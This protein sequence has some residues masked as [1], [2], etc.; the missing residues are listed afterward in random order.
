MAIPIVIPKEGQ[1]M[2][3]ALITKWSIKKG[4]AVKLGDVLCE[5]ESEKASFDIESPVNGVVLAIFFDADTEAPVLTAIAAIG[6]EG[7]DYAHL[8]PRLSSG[9]MD[10]T[11]ENAE[12]NIETVE[13]IQDSK[14]VTSLDES[15]SSEERSFQVSPRA[16]KLAMDKGIP[17]SLI[18]SGKIGKG[19]VTERDIIENQW[20]KS[21]D[22]N[23]CETAEIPLTGVRKVISDKMLTSMQ[24]TAQFTLNCYVE[25]TGFLEYRKKLKNSPEQ[26]GINNITINDMI[27][28]AVAKS[29]NNFK[30]MNCHFCGDRIVK[31]NKV[32]LGCA[33]DTQRGLIVPVI[34]N[35]HE[36]SLERISEEAK[37]LAKEC[38]EG[39]VKSDELSGG[40]FTVSNL[41]NLGIDSFTPILNL[42]QVGI[43]GIGGI[44]LRPVS[45]D[46]KVEFVNHIGLSLTVNHQVIDGA[47]AARFLQT[48]S[49]YIKNFN[50]IMV[51]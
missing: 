1:S 7:E 40:T 37:R 39:K 34:K 50:I 18:T 17:L 23:E 48:V 43:L 38:R 46:G 49:Q 9:N 45:K 51:I 30:E 35:A 24:T 26:L 15:S 12:A 11:D 5:V 28:Y 29:L 41:G 33:V 22:E 36:L 27:L 16:K 25:A 47:V 31:F 44:N 14:P 32:H 8:R 42:P 19:P 13:G 6:N 10:G 2:E 3:T 4:D 21:R 20:D